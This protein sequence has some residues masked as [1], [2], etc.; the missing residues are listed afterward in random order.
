VAIG[1]G[2][3]VALSAKSSYDSVAP[4]CPAAGCYTSAYD[5][6]QSARSQGD[7]ATGVMVAGAA[8]LAGGLL[9]FV[10]APRASVSAHVALGPASAR[11]VVPFD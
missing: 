9:L 11:L 5:T 10:L 4:Q 6:R 8:A 2:G 1:V 7:V 3:A